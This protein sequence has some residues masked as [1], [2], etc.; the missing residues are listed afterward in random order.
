MAKGIIVH[1]S[2][3]SWVTC[4]DSRVMNPDFAVTPKP[5]N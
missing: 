3:E 4:H 1:G 5:V 2:H